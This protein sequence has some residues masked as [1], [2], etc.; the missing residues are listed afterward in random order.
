MSSTNDTYKKVYLT[1]SRVE[2]TICV[3]VFNR[4]SVLKVKYEK[5][6]THPHVNFSA[7][8]SLV[9]VWT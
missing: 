9:R 2:C 4:A 8:V 6:P 7:R 3:E 5:R 1:D